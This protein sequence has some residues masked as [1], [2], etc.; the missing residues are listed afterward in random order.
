MIRLVCA[1]SNGLACERDSI[2]VQPSVFKLDNTLHANVNYFLHYFLV[3]TI[4]RFLAEFY[5]DAKD[6][7]KDFKYGQ[8]LVGLSREVC[9]EVESE[10]KFHPQL[11]DVVLSCLPV[12]T[13]F[14]LLCTDPN[15]TQRTGVTCSGP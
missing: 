5:E 11:G 2:A 9:C 6:G 4:K 14:V 13:G 1:K 8:Q 15:C 10:E 7:G 12:Y 3:E